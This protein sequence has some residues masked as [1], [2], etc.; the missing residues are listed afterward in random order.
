MTPSPGIRQTHTPPLITCTRGGYGRAGMV[1]GGEGYGQAWNRRGEASEEAAV[2]NSVCTNTITTH[3]PTCPVSPPLPTSIAHYIPPRPTQLGSTYP[4]FHVYQAATNASHSSLGALADLHTRQTS[5]SALK[6]PSAPHDSRHQVGPP[7]H[8]PSPPHSPAATP[9]PPH[10][11]S[12]RAFRQPAV[13]LDA[14]GCEPPELH[15][16]LR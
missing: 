1:A 9:A 16:R 4:G 12:R 6:L 3:T 2:L 5:T 7:H 14:T 13:S 11:S 15:R 10:S 8:S